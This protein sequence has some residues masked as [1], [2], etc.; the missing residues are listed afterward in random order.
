MTSVKDRLSNSHDVNHLKGTYNRMLLNG[1]NENVNYMI[2]LRK[3]IKD[4]DSLA[5]SLETNSVSE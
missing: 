5:K 1:E 2:K 4:L 3:I